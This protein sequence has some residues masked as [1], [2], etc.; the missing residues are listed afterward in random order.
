MLTGC[1]NQPAQTATVTTNVATTEITSESANAGNISDTDDTDITNSSNENTENTENIN[2]SEDN[3]D[4]AK[5][6]GFI[7][8]YNNI[9]IYL[10]EYMGRILGE[11]GPEK[12]YYE[13]PSCA[14]EGMAKIYSYNG[15]D[16]S[17][18]LKNKTDNDRVY[19]ITFNDDS[20][21]TVEG[22]YIGQTFDDMISVYGT[23]YKEY[24]EIPGLYKYE[25]G[26]TELSFNIE[27]DIIISISYQVADIY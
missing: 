22:I 13:S 21:S 4:G 19:S 17:N 20:I 7:F 11:L 23:E 10:G 9:T 12:D 2:N 15:F 14:F 25:K 8:I 1:A 27:N 6:D 5:K 3:E 18:Y 24:K 26:G 16:I